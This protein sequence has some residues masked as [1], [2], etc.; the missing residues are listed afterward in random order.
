MFSCIL[1]IATSPLSKVFPNICFETQQ[2]ALCILD[3]YGLHLDW[4]VIETQENP[5]TEIFLNFPVMD[6]NINVFWG[7]P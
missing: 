5:V 2:R 3:P 7:N 4:K 6:M 1:E